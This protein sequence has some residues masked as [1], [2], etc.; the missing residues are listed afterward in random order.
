MDRAF[1]LTLLQEN[2]RLREQNEKLREQ[3]ADLSK[4]TVKIKTTYAND[5]VYSTACIHEHAMG[6]CFWEHWGTILWY[7]DRNTP[8]SAECTKFAEEF[9][10][11]VGTDFFNLISSRSMMTYVHDGF[12]L[13]T[14]DAQCVAFITEKEGF[15]LIRRIRSH[16]FVVIVRTS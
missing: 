6:S 9:G 15:D 16:M 7:A 12:I 13:Q 3:N 5:G 2:D 8:V 4:M 1:V 10:V 14:S 11:P